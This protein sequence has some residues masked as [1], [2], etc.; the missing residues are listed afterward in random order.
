MNEQFEAQVKFGQLTMTANY[1]Y[2]RGAMADDAGKMKIGE[3]CYARG[4][5]YDKLAYQA[6]SQHLQAAQGFYN[7]V[8]VK[9]TEFR[10]LYGHR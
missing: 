6:A 5:F 10:S 7:R 1:W 3:M 2:R 4:R 8:V 9:S